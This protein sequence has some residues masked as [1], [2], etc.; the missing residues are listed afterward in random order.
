M[1]LTA[2]F[3]SLIAQVGLK[4]LAKQKVARAGFR[5]HEQIVK[6]APLIA[7]AALVA[8]A[9]CACGVLAMSCLLPRGMHPPPQAHNG[10]G[11]TTC[12][13]LGMLGRVDPQLNAPQ[14]SS[15]LVPVALQELA[16]MLCC[17]K[18]IA[19]QKAQC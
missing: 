6:M 3:R 1:I 17:Y 7:R 4:R 13:T 12:F 18:F 11:K 15:F 16:C 5:G 2:P 9:S 14:V 8:S 19:V 10:S